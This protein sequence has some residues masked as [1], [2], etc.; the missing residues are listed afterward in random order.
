[1]NCEIKSV[2]EHVHYLNNLML[3][4]LYYLNDKAWQKQQLHIGLIARK[5]VFGVSGEA[6][7]KP[8]S[9]TTETI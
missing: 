4:H 1:M 9:S 3:H 8:V 5:A 6:R 7:F 2:L